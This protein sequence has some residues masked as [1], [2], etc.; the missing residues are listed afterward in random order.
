MDLKLKGKVALVTGSSKGVG[1]ATV[2]VRSVPTIQQPKYQSAAAVSH[3]MPGRDAAGVARKPGCDSHPP[4]PDGRSNAL[5]Q[6][7]FRNYSWDL[8]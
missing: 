4:H 1:R 5:R 7:N 3:T 6:F 8:R 2:C